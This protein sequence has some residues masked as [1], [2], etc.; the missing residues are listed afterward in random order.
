MRKQETTRSEIG[1]E[2]FMP[3]EARRY[4]SPMEAE[5]RVKEA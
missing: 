5:A 2:P 3:V 4:T 1:G